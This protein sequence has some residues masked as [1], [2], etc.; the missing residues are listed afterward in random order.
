MIEGDNL[1]SG[2]WDDFWRGFHVLN[3][4]RARQIDELLYD[5]VK[6]GNGTLVLRVRNGALRWVS[7]QPDL[8]VVR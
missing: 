8:E 4:R 2:R 6:S 7:P 1:R 3:D 5:L